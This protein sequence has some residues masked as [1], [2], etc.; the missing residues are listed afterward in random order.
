[1]L[2]YFLGKLEQE[3]KNACEKRRKQSQMIKETVEDAGIYV[4]CKFSFH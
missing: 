2:A 3:V 1:L 4:S